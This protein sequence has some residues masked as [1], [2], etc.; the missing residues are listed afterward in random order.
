MNIAD[1]IE[2]IRDAVGV[3]AGVWADL[4]AGTGTF[5]RA[6]T[7][8]L[9]AGS[10]VYAV[11]G[12]ARAERA[13]RELSSSASGKVRVIAVHADF[14][15]PLDVPGLARADAQ[16]D[17][18]LLA[19]ALHFVRDAE[20]VLSNLVKRLRPGGRVFVVEYDRR[21]AS[22]WVPYPIPPSRW[23]QLA[24]S[25]GLAEPTITATRPSSY[26]GILY[27]GVATRPRLSERR[28]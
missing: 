13:L 17:G 26:S 15:R 3:S 18:I 24:E 27:T 23:R 20:G 6:L 16:L 19:N 21:A 1:A 4:G 28:S 8:V 22:Q 25:A 14:T 2:M 12:D 7:A 5:T 10:T 9:G 11:D